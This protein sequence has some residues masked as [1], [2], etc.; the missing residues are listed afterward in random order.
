MEGSILLEGIAQ[1]YSYG[2]ECTLVR[3]N[4][5]VQLWKGVYCCKVRYSCTVIERSVLL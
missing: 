2:R 1:L 3:Y 5:A 4:T